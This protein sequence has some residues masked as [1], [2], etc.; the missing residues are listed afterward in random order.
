MRRGDV[1]YCD[2]PEQ[3]GHIQCGI[4][5]CVIISNNANNKYA[6]IYNVVPLSTFNHRKKILPCHWIFWFNGRMNISLCEQITT[7][8]AERLLNK[9]GEV[10]DLDLHNI[11]RVLLI[12]L[13]VIKV[14]SAVSV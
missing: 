7:I 11:E 9:I 4:R 13:G 5:P 10:S 3:E 8:S 1:Y 12:Q 2:L 14:E 6:G